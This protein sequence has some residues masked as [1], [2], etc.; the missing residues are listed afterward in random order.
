[1]HVSVYAMAAIK[2]PEEV[3]QKIGILEAASGAGIFIGPVL[4][5]AL[6]DASG[7]YCIPFF[8]FAGMLLACAPLIM[9]NLD[10][11]LDTDRE[12]QET[13]MGEDGVMKQQAGA[14]S[15]LSYKRV[16]FAAIAQSINLVIFTLGDPIFGPHLDVAGLSPIL[17]GVCFGLPTITYIIT[18]PF[19]L[20]KLTA[21]FEK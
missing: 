12:I 10:K 18:G 11:S 14:L 2:W 1:M 20:Q 5:S 7:V 8:V 16:L 4:G 13:T 9:I 17:I 15:M 6:Y 21:H 3:Q 19:L